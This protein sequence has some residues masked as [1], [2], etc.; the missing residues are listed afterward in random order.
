MR[1]L[2]HLTWDSRQVVK[3]T[4]EQPP[5][6]KQPVQY[7]Q[8]APLNNKPPY[9]PPHPQQ[10]QNDHVGKGN[11]MSKSNL[12]VLQDCF[13]WAA[14]AVW[15]HFTVW[16]TNTLYILLHI[17]NLVNLYNPQLKSVNKFGNLNNILKP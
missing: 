7:V 8:R 10:P 9:R 1:G 13:G 3:Y 2:N 5:T 17:F 16:L 14:K 6:P 11:P 4:T 12:P 15:I